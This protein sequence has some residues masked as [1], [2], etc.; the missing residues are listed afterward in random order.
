LYYLWWEAYPAP[1]VQLNFPLQ[2][3]ESVTASVAF[4]HGTFLLSLDVPGERV[5]FSVSQPGK[6]SDTK[7]AE[8]IVEPATIIDDPATNKEHLLPLTDFDQV[9]IQCQLNGNEPIAAGPQDI[10]YQMQTHTG[11]PKAFTS[12]LDASGKTFTVQWHHA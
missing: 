2:A 7:I 3:G 1:S 9:T 12:V 11:I 10:L 6:V 4:Q 5:H 8:C